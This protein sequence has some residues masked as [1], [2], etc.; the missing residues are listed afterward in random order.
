MNT[1]EEFTFK[2]PPLPRLYINKTCRGLKQKG[3]RRILGS[4]TC[5]LLTL[6]TEGASGWRCDSRMYMK[7]VSGVRGGISPSIKLHTL[8]IY[9][10]GMC[11]CVRVLVGDSTTFDIRLYSVVI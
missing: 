5:T 9:W 4:A 7:I 3:E 2:Q 8:Y 10:Y 1:S 11:V 6:V